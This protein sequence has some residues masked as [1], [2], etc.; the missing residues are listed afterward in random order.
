M[1]VNLGF[2]DSYPKLRI[3][4]LMRDAEKQR[5]VDLALG[6][7]RPLR[8]VIAGWLLVTAAWLD[9]QPHGAIQSAR[10]GVNS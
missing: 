7:R 6:P 4:E 9:G 10:A 8:S 5:L 2:L 3:E 1:L